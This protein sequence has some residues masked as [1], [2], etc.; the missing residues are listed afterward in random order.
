[1]KRSMTVQRDEGR[2]SADD[3]QAYVLAMPLPRPT[4]YMAKSTEA[5]STLLLC[6]IPAGKVTNHSSTVGQLKDIRKL[7]STD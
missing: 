6:Y 5:V 1:M 2:T 4:M 3:I 7:S